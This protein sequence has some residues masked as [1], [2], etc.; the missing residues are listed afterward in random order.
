MAIF[1]RDCRKAVLYSSK[2]VIELFVKPYI[3]L[4]SNAVRQHTQSMT[5]VS[6]LALSFGRAEYRISRGQAKLLELPVSQVRS[7]LCAL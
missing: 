7:A 1:L 4:M 2:A 3:L 6:Q 5:G